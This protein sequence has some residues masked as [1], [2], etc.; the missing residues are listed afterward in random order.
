[1]Y[2]NLRMI[3]I[4]KRIKKSPLA[5]HDYNGILPVIIFHEKKEILK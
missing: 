5:K 1:M 3:A 4:M 2:E